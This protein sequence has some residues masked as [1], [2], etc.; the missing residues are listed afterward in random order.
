MFSYLD[1][2]YAEI[3]LVLMTLYLYAKILNQ[4]S[5]KCYFLQILYESYSYAIS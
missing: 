4:K 2:N 5:T 1:F 3:I